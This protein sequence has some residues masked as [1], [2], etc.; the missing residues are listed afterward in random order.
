MPFLEQYIPDKPIYFEMRQQARRFLSSS[1][2]GNQIASLI[3][4]VVIFAILAY[5]FIVSAKWIHVSIP[6]FFLPI[7]AGLMLPGVLSGLISG[8]IQKRS[9]ESLMATPLT[10]AQLVFAKALRAVMPVLA[11]VVAILALIAILLIGKLIYGDDSQGDFQSGWL[12]IPAGIVIYLV[13]S[14]AVTGICMAVSAVTRSAVA[15]MITTYG[16]M[17]LIYVII[18][19]IV[20]PIFIAIAGSNGNEISYLASLHPYGMVV[21]ATINETTN[22]VSGMGIFALIVV[23]LIIQLGIGFLGLAFASSRVEELKRKGI[24]G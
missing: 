4:V 13:F 17:M 9:M 14:Y 20:T 15:S 8:E 5:S 6:I 11:G 10:S 1:M 16:V 22:N 24:E 18:P 23:G 21:L 19:A 7:L 12:S 3:V 2:K